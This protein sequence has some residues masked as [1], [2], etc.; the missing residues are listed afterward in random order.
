VVAGATS[1]DVSPP[2]ATV[3]GASIS[4]SMLNGVLSTEITHANAQ[5]AAQILAGQTKSPIGIGTEGDTTTP[6]AV[7][8]AFADAQ[9]FTLVLQQIETQALARRGVAVTAADVAAARIDYPYQLQQSQA[10]SGSPS[11]CALNT[12]TPLAKQL[13]AGFLQRQTEILAAQEQFEVAVDHVDVSL[14]ALTSYYNTHRSLV[15]QECLNIVLA[16][17]QSAA[18]TL[19][20]EIASGTTFPVAAKAAGADQQATP[21]GG[22]LQCGYPT[23][24]NSQLGAALGATVDALGAGQLSE[25]LAWQTTN[26]QTGAPVT[27]YLVVQMRQHYLV[28]F[29]TLRYQIRQAILAQNSATFEV[30]LHKAVVHAQVTVD[31]RYGSWN[32]ARGIVAPAP[33]P[34]AFVPNAPANVPAVPLNIGGLSI[35]PTAG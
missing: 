3:D 16:D 18:Q 14:A 20:D 21:P 32:P 33:P 4:Q 6:N 23:G 26:R 30:L 22:Q 2:A 29:A 34:P 27:F 35:N 15:T 10:Q 11:G 1:C 8:P 12:A 7:S 13:P 28:P 24:L 19:H 25:P 5:C 31:P 17:S 9:L